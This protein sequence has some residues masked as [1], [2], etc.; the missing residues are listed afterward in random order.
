MNDSRLIVASKCRKDIF[1]VFTTH[2]IIFLLG[3]LGLYKNHPPISH[4]M[5]EVFFL[6]E[7]YS[8]HKFYDLIPTSIRYRT[9]RCNRRLRF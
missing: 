2:V 5:L 9:R 1:N 7:F 8:S 3:F 4:F 6:C